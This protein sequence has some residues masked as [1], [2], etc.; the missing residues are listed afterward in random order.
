M[1]DLG[2]PARQLKRRESVCGVDRI[3]RK[4]GLMRG[5]VCLV[6]VLSLSGC[7]WLR[8]TFSFGGGIGAAAETPYRATA[9]AGEDNRDLAVTVSAGP[10]VPLEEFRESARYAVT[11][12]C[13]GAFGMSEADWATDSAT[14]DWAVTRTENAALLQAR[15]TGR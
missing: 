12:Y 5:A 4:A 6:L 2:N 13:L 3:E 9:R 1:S 10:Q 11:R 8:D 15:C 14:G 7:G